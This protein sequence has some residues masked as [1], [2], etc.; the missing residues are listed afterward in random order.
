MPDPPPVTIAP[1][2]LTSMVSLLAVGIAGAI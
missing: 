2:P 1:K